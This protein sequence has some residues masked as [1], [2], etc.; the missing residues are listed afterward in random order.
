MFFNHKGGVGK[1]TLCFNIAKSLQNAGHNVLLVDA[2]PQCNLTALTL[3]E[4][5]IEKLLGTSEDEED[6]STIW[7][8]LRP[9]VLGRGPIAEVP[10][11]GDED[12]PGI[13][14]GDVML[15]EYEEELYKVWNDCY[16]SAT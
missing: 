4:E 10:V 9:V 7:S 6:G 8:A 5:K 14:A 15:S 16:G 2:D 3:S 13:L 12:A 11:Y 1:T